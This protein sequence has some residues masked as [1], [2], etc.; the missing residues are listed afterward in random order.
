MGANHSRTTA[1]N[2]SIAQTPSTV[3]GAANDVVNV[4]VAV[5]IPADNP[6][7]LT[8]TVVVPPTVGVPEITPV[9][10]ASES[11][12]GKVPALTA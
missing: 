7:P 10:V 3:P 4:M 8:V 5:A 1:F 12:A 2:P 11:P 6:V 9:L